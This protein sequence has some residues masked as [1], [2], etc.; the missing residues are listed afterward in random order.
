[1]LS[2]HHIVAPELRRYLPPNHPRVEAILQPQTLAALQ[3]LDKV[4]RELDTLL[5]HGMTLA[6]PADL[7]RSPPVP[8]NRVT[9]TA[10]ALAAAA[11][12]ILIPNAPTQPDLLR[13]VFALATQVQTLFQ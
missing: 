10:M 8:S 7:R 1:M 13:P 4:E 11:A 6:I 12:A 9:S 5:G 2:L 3:A